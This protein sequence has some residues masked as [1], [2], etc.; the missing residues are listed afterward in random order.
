MAGCA[1]WL[2]CVCVHVPHPAVFWLGPYTATETVQQLMSDLGL[3]GL[4]VL[5]EGGGGADDAFSMGAAAL[6]FVPDLGPEVD[7]RHAASLLVASLARLA[8]SYLPMSEGELMFQPRGIKDCIRRPHVAHLTPS[9]FTS[10]FELLAASVVAC[11]WSPEVV[12]VAQVRLGRACIVVC[13]CVCVCVGVSVC[14]CVAWCRV[15]A[16]L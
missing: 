2:P 7:A 13:V 6:G 3:R 16:R 15:P 9:S 10:I 5:A 12:A 11:K 14:W 8:S 4:K 1:R